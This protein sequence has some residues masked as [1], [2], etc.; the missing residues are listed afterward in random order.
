MSKLKDAIKA[1]KAE[2]FHAQ[3]GMAFYARRVEA[4]EQAL[5]QIEGVDVGQAVNKAAST[6]R[7]TRQPAVTTRRSVKSRATGTGGAE[8]PSTGGDFWS[9]MISHEQISAP[10]ILRAAIDKL[11]FTP[12]K[13]QVRKLSA[14]MTMALN[15]LVKTHQI[16][17]TGRGRA[18]RYF[19]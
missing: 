18:R 5:R 1:L 3:Q 4:L 15:A 14:R 8:L 17:D 6:S 9:S 13:E 11:G 7:A 10:E 12:S 16:Q 2:L 19:K